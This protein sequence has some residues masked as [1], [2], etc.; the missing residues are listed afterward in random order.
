MWGGVVGLGRGDEREGHSDEIITSLA[1]LLL[2]QEQK[3]RE[4]RFGWRRDQRSA[5]EPHQSIR[6]TAPVYSPSDCLFVLWKDD[7]V[8]GKELSRYGFSHWL[9]SGSACTCSDCLVRLGRRL[10]T[11]RTN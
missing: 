3:H 9:L 2:P 6:N 4:I 10:N 7:A 11:Y 8:V 5:E 1:A